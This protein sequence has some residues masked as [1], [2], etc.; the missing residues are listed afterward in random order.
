MITVL[1]NWIYI[2]ITTYLSGNACM[3]LLERLFRKEGGNWRRAPFY[4][5]FAG[6]MC[7][8]CYAQIYS[9]FG[10]VGV[11]ANIGL[12]AFCLIYLAL[13]RK[14]IANELGSWFVEKRDELP[15]FIKKVLICVLI[16]GMA[17]YALATSGAPK[18]IDTDWYHAQ[19]IRW[20]EEYGCV[21]G[22]A[23]LFYSL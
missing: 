6:I 18:L 19:T 23:N 5:L 17:A 11:G 9:L 16:F 22:V 15:S 10:G 1:I 7:T 21:T 20:I 8:T 13:F 3:R 4:D 12:L 14:K 2:A